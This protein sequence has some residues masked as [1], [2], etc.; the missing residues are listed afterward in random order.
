MSERIGG[1]FSLS[2]SQEGIWHA[3]RLGG[4]GA[5]Y[6]VGQAVE[7]TGALDVPAFEAALRRTVEETEILGL[8]FAEDAVG[9]VRVVPHP[10]RRWSLR[11]EEPDR[12]DGD[13]RAWMETRMRE[14]LAGVEDP[15]G[16]RLFS[17]LLFRLDSH[18]YC[19]FQG[20]NHLLLDGYACTLMADR[21]AEVYSALVGGADAICPEAEFVSL[22]E[23]LDEEERYR[24]SPEFTEDRRYLCDRFSDR[25]ELAEVPRLSGVSGFLKETGAGAGAGAV[26]RE[27]GSLASAATDALRSAADRVGLRTSRLLAAASGAFV[28]GMAGSAEALLSLPVTGRVSEADL[29]AR[30]TRANMLPLR[31]PVRA[32]ASLLDLARTADGALGELLR[33]Q[34]YRGEHLRRELGW[35]EGDRWHFGPYLNILPRTG[36]LAFGDCR[37]V[38]RDV[39]TRLV[40]DFGVLIDRA[41]S[42]IEITV[43]ANAALYDRAWVRAVQRSLVG[44]IAR[45]AE[46]PTAPVRRIG[47]VGDDERALVTSGWSGTARD[48]DA[49]MVV[50]RFR[51]WAVRTPGA[52]ALRFGQQALS[53]GELAARSDMLARGLVARGVGRESR[54]GLCLPR[55]AEMVVALLAVWKAGGAYVPLDPE[56]PAERLAFMVA[57]SG[58]ELVLAAEETVDRLLADVETVLVG[59]LGTD[60]GVLPDVPSDQLA[61]VIYTSGSTGRP[62]G[63]AVA[64]ASVAN[65]ASAMGPVLGVEPGVTALQFASFSFD[66]AVLDVAVTLA[67]GGTLAIA[68]AEERQDGAA[69]AAMVEAAGVEVASVVPSLLGVLEPNSVPGVGNWVLGA[70]RLEA[71]LA[72]KW[73]AGARVWNT[74]GPT[75]ATVI[76][77]ATLLEADITGEDVPPA[78][79]SPLPDIRTYVLD[80]FLRPVP[81]GVAGELYIAGS[82]LAR[83]YIGRA[84]LTAERFVACPF[85]DGGGRMYRTG[86]LA[87]W[88]A[89]GQLEFVGRADAQVKIRGFRVE[90][91]EVE[92]VLA[93]H[94]QVERAVVVVRDGRLVG[95]VVGDADGED[96]REFA[97]TRLPEYMVPSAVVVL[98]VFPLTVNGKVDRV[99]LPMPEAAPGGG[100]AAATPAEE[101]FCALFAEV[102]GLEEVGV[103]ESFFALGGDS[104]T[105]MLLVSRSRRAGL[106]VGA[107]QVHELRTPAQLA[108]VATPVDGAVDGA[109]P[110]ESAAGEVPLT[111]VM[112][113]V[114][115]RVGAEGVRAVV[116]SMVVEAPAGLDEAA[117]RDAMAALVERHAVLRA[118]LVVESGV[119]V[120]PETDAVDVPGAVAR[121]DV[122]GVDPAVVVGEQVEAAVG[123]LD[124]AAGVMVQVVW[125]DAGP[126]VPGRLVVVA[127]HLV[128]DAVSWQVLLP[129]LWSAYEALAEGRAVELD[130]VPV[131]F[132]AWA[133]ELAVE[134][135]RP[136]RVAELAAW[137]EVVDGPQVLLTDAPLDPLMDVGGTVREV[138]VTVPVEVTSAL[139]AAVP[140]AFHAGVDEV[141]LAGLVGAIG[142]WAADVGGFLVDVEGHGREPLSGISDLS[143]TVGWFT[144]SHPVR[145]AAG[146]GADGG[147][148]V[149]GVKEQVRAVPGDG[150]GY[151]LLRY[152]NPETADELAELPSAQVGFN[153]LGRVGAGHDFGAGSAPQAPVMHALELLGSVRES[154]EGPVL[155]LRLAFP[156]R[157]LGVGRARG[158]V[159]AWAGVLAD[160]VAD[161][162]AGA[163]GYSPSDFP[164]VALDQAGVEEIEAAVPGLAE[165]LPVAPLQEGLLFHSLFDEDGVDVYVE[166]MVLGLDGEVDGGRLRA[167]WQALVDR[168]AALRAGFVQAAGAVGPVQVVVERAELPWREVDLTELGDD[169]ADRVGAE[170]RS[171]RFDL[172]A[173]PLLR[174]ALVR[175]G[176]RRF[177]MVVTLHHLLLD[178]WSLPLVMRELWALYAAGGRASGLGVPVSSRPYWAWLAGRDMSAALEAW[179]AE[180]APVEEPTLVAPTELSATASVV[181]DRVTERASV[182]LVRDLE[183]VARGAGV[184]LNT[185]VQLAW[186]LVLGQLTGRREVVFGATVAGRPAELPGM[187][188]MLGLFINTLPVRVDLDGA[189]SVRETLEA[190]QA[191]QSALLD[192]QHVG[193]SEVQRAAGL[194]A[195]FDTLLAFENYPGNLD[196]QPLG[197]GLAVTATELRE[198]TNFALA[199]GVTPAPADGLAIRLDY[200]SGLFRRWSALRMARRLVRVLEQMAAD[201]QLRL[202]EIELLDGSE[203][204]AVVEEWNATDRMAEPGT[205][206]ERFRGWAVRTPAAAALW[207]GQQALSY[208][209]LAARSDMLARG[210][211]ARG[212]GRESRVGLCL[213]RG[214]EMVVALLA[215]WKAGGAYV[216]LDPEYPAERLAFMVADSGAELVL[217]AEETV[218]LLSVDVETVLLGELGSDSGDLPEV[219]GGQLA[220]VIYTSG[221]TGRPK[222]VAVTHA[223]VAN[224]ASAMRP[225]LGVEPGVAALQFASF[226]FDAAVL[227]VAV[228]LAAGGTLAIASA[229]ERQD[230]SALA[231]MVAAAGVEV[232]S[233][234]PSLLGV[235][236]SNSVPGVGNWVLGAERLEAGLAA[237][238]RA[239]AR[240]WNT[241]GP[242]E[243]TVITTAVLLEEGITGEDAPPAIGRPLPNVRT[244]V[245]D[246]F[247]RPVPDGV[248]G[249]L[250]VAG[251]GLARGYINRPD[252]TA[253]RF[254]ACPFGDGGRMYRTGDLARWAG[255]G[256]LEFVGRA[257]AQVKI[258]GFRVELGEVETVL[259]GHALVE[260]AVVVARDGRL[261]GY[262]LGDVEAEALRE[263]AATRLPEY[264][265]PSAVVVLDVFPLTVNG[266]VDRSALPAPDLAPADTRAPSTEVEE[267]FCALFAEV[268]GLGQVGLGDSF[269]ALGGDSIMSM[270]LASRARSAGWTMSPRQIFEEKTPERL[271]QVAGASSGTGDARR[272]D[273][274]VGEVP[275]T[276]VMRELLDRVGSERVGRIVQPGVLTLPPGLDRE[277]LV[278]A[279]H[280][281]MER[282]EVLRA[283]LV[284]ESG[285]LVV[286]ESPAV[287]VDG[288]VARVEAVG[289]DPAVLVGEQAEAAV[290]RLD[291]AAGVMVRVVWLDAGPEVPGRL[292]VVANHLVVDTVSWQVLLP[293]LQRALTMLGEGRA[294]ELEP[295]PV[296]FRAW[297]RELAVEAGRP[298]RVA[299]LPAWRAVV[300]GDGPD[301]LLTD[302]PLDPLVDVGATVRE[303]AVTVPAEVT[304]ALLTVV[305]SA[306]HAGVDEVLL[307]GLAGAVGEWA[308]GVGGFLVDVEGHGREP[309][310]GISDLSRTVGWFTSSRPVRLSAGVDGGVSVLGV[311]ERVRAVPGDG[312]GYGLLRWLNPETA[313]ELAGLPSAQVGFNYLGRV[314]TGEGF[315]A[316]GAPAASVMHAVELLCSVR[317]L[318]DGPV[319]ELRLAYPERLLGADRARALVEAWVDAL[320]GLA[321]DVRAG[322]GGHSPSDFPLVVLDQAGVEEVVAAVPGL[323]DVLPVAPLQEGLLFH[324]LFDEDGVDVYVEQMVLGLDGEVDGGRLRASWQALVDRHAALRAGFVQVAG[325]A[326]PVQVV[327]DR[328]ELPWREV[329]LTG[330]G[331]GAASRVG[332]EER[333]ARF[334]L[335]APPL[336]RVALVRVGH[337]QYQMVVTLHHLLLDGWS[338]PLVMRELWALYAADGRASGLGV[339]VSSRPYWTWLAGRDMSAAL[340]AWRAE[341]APIEEPTLVAPTVAGTDAVL[342]QS[343][344]VEAREGLVEGLERVARGAG[345][346][347]NTVVQL[348]WGLVLGQ[349]TGRRE[350]VFGATVAGRPAELPGMEAMLGLFINT[351]PVRVDLDGARS[352]RET[353][354]ALQARQSALL[355]H[356]HV[357]LSEVQRAAGPG[358][359]FDTLLAF[360]NYP[361]D[362]AAQPSAAGLTISG[363]SSRESTSFALALGVRPEDGLTLRL[364]YRPDAFD[365]DAARTLI[366][367]VVRALERIA[368]DPTVRLAELELLD[369][370]ERAVVVEEWNA[371]ARPTEPGTVLERFRRWAVET[372]QATAVRSGDPSQ[373]LSYA[374]LD[375]RSDA[376]ARGLV[377]RGVGRESRVGLCLPRGVEM[378][379]AVLAV[380]KAGGAYVPLDPEYPSERLAFM[381]GDSDAELVLVAEET[382]GRLP[383]EVGTVLPAELE[384]EFGEGPDS[385]AVDPGQL[386]Y[387]IYTSGSTGR[388]KGVAVAHASVAN[389]ASAMRPVLGVEPGVTA[390]QFASFGF[391]AAVLDVAVTLA[392][393]G[394]LA[395]ASSEERQDPS[396]LAAMVES[397][398]VDSASVVPSLLGALEPNSVPGVRNW[399]LG[400]ERLE[401]GLAARWREGARVWNTY[402]P[403]EATVI[404][405]AVLLEEGITGEDAPPVIGSPL[406][407]IRTYVLDAFLRPVPVGVA[408]ELYIAGSGLARGYVGRADLTAERFVACPF[409]DG[410]GRM[411]RTGD[412]VRWTAD[413]LLDFVGRADAQVKIRGFRVEL[414]EVETVLAAHAQV[415][416]AVVLARDGRLIGYTVGDADAEELRA[417]A[418]TRLPEY[419]VPSAVVVL[420]TFPLTVNGKIDRSALP[421]PDLASIA[422]RVPATPGEEAFCAL[423]A[424]VLGLEDVGVGDGFFELGG[425]SIMS[426]QLA[427]RARRSGWVVTPRQIFEE[428][429]PERLALV[430]AVSEDVS[431]LAGD[432]GVGEVPLTPVMRELLDRVGQAAVARIVQPGV[433]AAPAGLDLEVLVAALRAVM[434]RH[435]VLR[436][437]LVV[438]SGV[439]AVPEADAVDVSGLVARVDVAGVDPA[440]VVGEQVEAAVGRLDPAAGVMVQVVWLDAGPEVPGR[441]VVVA[442]HL[443]VDTVSWQVVLPDLELACTALAEGRPVELDPV[444]VSFRAW[445]RELA[446]EA[447]RPERVAELPAWRAVVAGDG[448]DAL[449]T[450]VPLDP[451][452]DVGGTVR[453]VAV[454]VPVEVTSALLTVVPSAFHAGVDEVLLAGL[455]GAVGEWSA[456]VGDGF[457]VDVEGHGREP[458]SGISDLSRTVGW[459]TSSRPVRLSAGVDGGVS[460]LGVKERVRA[461]PG[462]GLG[463]GLLRYVNSE[464]ADELAGLPSAQV[465]FN[466]LGRVGTGEG[467]GAGGAPEASVMHAV[468]LLG[469]VR[470]LTDGS[471][472]EL[473][474]A[475]PERLLEADRARALLEVWAEA[476]SGLVEQVRDGAG[477]HSPSDFPLVSLSQGGV[478]ELELAVPGLEDVWPLSPLQEGLLFHSSF[479]DEAGADVYAGQRALALDG[480]LDVARLRASW[481]VVLGRHAIL[482]AGFHRLVS[483]EAVQVVAREVE[484]PWREVDLSGLSE[485]AAEVEAARLSGEELSAGFDL[486]RG[487]LLRLLLLRLGERRHR[488]VMTTHH[489][490]LD[491]WSLPILLNE[492]QTVYRAG[493]GVQALPA[494]RSYRDYLSWLGRQD[495][496]AARAV[497]REELAG[498]EEP[499][500]VAPVDPARLPMR[501]EAVRVECSAELTRALNDVAR[502]GGVTMATV[503]QGAWALVLA[504]LSGRRDVV[505]GTTVA[506]RP[507]DLPGAESLIGLF[508]NTLP[509]RVELDGGESVLKMLDRLQRRRLGV[510]G[511][512][513]LGLA[514]IKQVAGPGA[515][516]DTLVVYENYPQSAEA[517]PDD[518]DALTIRPGGRTRDASHYPLGL[519]VAPGERMELQ[520]DHRP[521]LFDQA[522]AEE[523]LA[524]LVRVLEQFAEDPEMLLGRVGLL[525]AERLDRLTRD[526]QDISAEVPSGTLPDLLAEQVRRTP[527]APAL[528][529]GEHRLTYAELEAEAGRLA[530]YLIAVGVGPERRVAVVAERS[531]D[532]V[533]AL[534]A[535][536]MA[537]GAFVPLDP[538]HPTERLALVLEDSDP[539]AVLCTRASRAVLP[540]AGRGRATALDD[541]GV[542]ASV[543]GHAP[544]RVVDAERIVPLGVANAAYV[545]HTSGSTGRP[546][547]VV[548]SHAGLANLAW[549]QIDRFAVHAEARVLQFASLSFD[550]AVSELCM[551]LVSGAV[552]VVAGAEGL[553]PRVSLGEAVDRARATHVT[554]PPGVLAVEEVL[555]ES[556]ETLVVAGEAC[557]PG[558]VD[559]WSIG[560]R[561]VNAYG[562]TEVTVCAAMSL[563]LTLGA[564]SRTGAGDTDG[565]P[566]G[567][568]TANMRAYVLDEFLQPVPVGVAGELYVSGPG[569]ARGYSGRPDLTAERFVADPFDAGA[570]MYRTGDLVRWLPEGQLT[571]VGRADEQVKIRGFRIELGEVEAVLDDHPEVAQAVVTVRD[572]RLVAHVVGGA[573]A[574][575][576]REFVAVRLPEYMV[577]AAVVVLDAFPLTV[578][579]KVDRA[580][581]PAPEFGGSASGRQPGTAAE[582]AFRALFAEALGLA[583]GAIGV[584]DSFFELGGDSIMSMQLASR[585]RRSGWVVTPRQIFEEKTPERLAL[586]AVVSEDA[587][588]V[589]GDTGVGEVPWTPL[590]R[591]MGA[592]VLRPGFAQ[593][594][595]IGAPADLGVDAL[596]SGVEALL[597][598]HGMLRARAGDD[599]VLV[600]PEA[601][602]IDA[603]GLVARV[604]AVETAEEELDR[605]AAEAARLAVGRLDPAA[606][607]MVQVVWVD[608]GPDRVGRI[609]LAGHHLAVDGVSWRV[610]VPDLQAACEAAGAGRRPDLA[611]APTSFRAWAEGLRRAAQG[612]TRVGELDAWV[613]M[614]AGTAGDG[615][616]LVG[617]RALDPIVDTVATLRRRSWSV[618]VGEA[619]VLVGEVPGVFHCGLHEVLLATLAGAVAG[620]RT[621]SAGPGGFLV[622]VEGHGREPL[623]AGVDLSRTVG[624]FTAAYPVRLDASGVDLAEATAGG[625]AAGD[626]LKRVKEQVQAVPGDG[627]GHGVLRWLNPETASALEALPVPRIGFNYLGRFATTGAESDV[628]VPWQ[629]V[630]D[631]AV[632]GAAD[633]GMPV[634]HA[635]DAGAVVADTASGPELTLTLSWPGALLDESDVEELGRTWLGLLSGLA[636]HTA[637]PLAGGHTPSDF[638]LVSLS[639]EGVEELESAVSGLEDVWPLSPLQEGLLFHASLDEGDGADVY[640]GQRALALDGPLDVGRLRASWDVVLGRHAILR[641]GFHRLASGEAV[642]VVAGEVELPW[643]ETDL[644]G[645]SEAEAEVEAA[646]LSEDEL[647]VGFDLARGPLLRLLLLRLGERRHRLVMTSHHSVVDGWSLSV[648]IDELSAAYAAGGDAG[649]LPAVRSYRDYLAWLGRQDREA[650]RAAWRE[651]LAGAEEPTLVAP[652]DPA[653]L[654]LRPEAVRAE[655][656]AELTR[657]L[658][659]LTRERGFTMATV[660]QGAWALVLARLS[661]RR[662]VVFGTTVA[663]RPA[664][665]PGAESLIGLFINTLPVRVELAG[666]LSVADLLSEL[667]ARQVN[668]MGH[669][670]L[671]LAE[672]KQLAGPGAEFDT[673]VVYENY[674][675]SAAATPDG[676]DALTIRPGGIPH[677]AS[678]YPLGLIVA[679]GERMELQLDHRPDLIDRAQADEVLAALV[680]VLERFAEDPEMP[681]GRLGLL[682]G[683]R[684][685]RLT[686]GWQDVSPEVPTGTLPDLLAEQVRRTPDAPALESVEAAGSGEHVVSYAELEAEAGRLARYLIAV[687]V[688]PERRVA[689][690]AE[691]SVDTVVA[692]LA[693]SMAGG[694]FVPLDPGH[695]TERLALVLEDSD[696]VAVLCTRATWPVLPEGVGGRAIVLDDPETVAAVAGCAPGRV[697]DA[698]RIVPLEV[699]NAAYVIHTSGSTGRPKGVVVSHAGLAN[700]AWAQI[701]RFAVH[702]RARVLQFASLSFDAAVSELCMALVSGAVLVVAGAEGLPPQVS[703]GEAVSLAR[704]THVTVPPGVLAVEEVLP[705]ALETLVVAG[706]A[707]PPGLVDR[708]STGRRMVNAYGPT[709][710]TVCAAMSLPLT[711]GAGGSVPIGRPLRNARTFVLDEFLQPVPVGVAG[712]L[713]VSGPG[714]ARGYAGRP[715]LTAERFVAAPF[716]EGERM[717]RTGD[718]IRWT[719]EGQLE[720][721]GRAD[722]QVKIRGFRIELGEV[723][724][725]LE[726]HPQADHAVVMVRE[727]RLVGYV[728]GREVDAD[729]LRVFAS[730]RLPE[731]MVPAAM[732]VLDAFPFTVNGKVDRAAL[733]DPEFAGSGSTRRPGTAAEEA[734]CALFA[735]VLG[736]AAGAIGV[737]DSFFELGGDSI[738][739]M[740]LASRARRSG[741]V[742]TPRQIFE[743]KTPERLALVAVVSEDASTVAGDTGVGEVP[744]TPLMRSMG[745]DV[746]R[747]GFAQWT[748]I[749]APADLGVD[750]LTSGVEALLRTHGMLRARAGDDQ[751]LV[752]PEAGEIDVSGLVARVDAVGLAEGELDRLAVDAA[753]LAVG[754]LDPAAGVMVQVVWVDA[755]PDR[756]GR[757]ALAGHHLAVDGVSWRVLV[758]D[759]QAACEAAAA[760]GTPELEAAG[761]S[762]RAW[763]EG[764]RRVAQSPTRVGELDAWVDMVAGSAGDGEPLIGRRALDPAVDTTSTLRLLSWSLPAE[765]A[766]V[767]VGET[768]R[769][770]HCGLH[771]LLLAT[772]AGAVTRRRPGSE[773]EISTGIGSDG[774]LV[775]V[776]GHGREPLSAGMDL[777]RTVGWFTA[778]YPVRLDA[779]GV[780]LDETAAGGTAAGALVKR[781]KEQVQAVPGDGLGHGLLRHLNPETAATLEALPVPQIG[782]N[783]LGRF[784]TAGAVEPGQVE[785]W[786]TAGD[787]AVGGAADPGMPVLHALA[788]GAVVADTASG[789]ELTLTLSWPAALL[790]ETDVAELGRAWLALLS[791]LAAHTAGPQAGGHTPSDFSLLDL[792]QDEVDDLEAI[793]AELDEGR[794]L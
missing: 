599:Q 266:K 376:V 542:V 570:R 588:T 135:G 6:S 349:L 793:A 101:T 754:R 153:Y 565:V 477:G 574:S 3:Q 707:C 78:I 321:A 611:S 576:L 91:G 536:S 37:G 182:D 330:L 491:G 220:Y 158:L 154:A 127:N 419:M 747:P 113:E 457:L 577:P 699:A 194:G 763:A 240:V 650:A 217:V 710:V 500:L 249:D 291:P 368:A 343:L 454:T 213:P 382:A 781:V 161:V 643:R 324:S 768:P 69:L 367:R 468:E 606:G 177:Q 410:G 52:A 94:P 405:T 724:A 474:L 394:T 345:V 87:R 279:V 494:V 74:Y 452:V 285:V 407:N 447:G 348:A 333:S 518:P 353:L 737:G 421:A 637:D 638:P 715:D 313:G 397:N 569:L 587:S 790:D 785:P 778:A 739:S 439:L 492:L 36:E 640:A 718:L 43:E 466:Y 64:H 705:P 107:R 777:S 294:V 770:F 259:A 312:L 105:A 202:S 339:P 227:D 634:L 700:L 428:K 117:L 584:G 222:G 680:R 612:P 119:L 524:A 689:V 709:E 57:D 170:E 359:T 120:V 124:P 753:R 331:D 702:E 653:R 67:A 45:V 567:R 248:T 76:T 126:E 365:G 714:L 734:L 695:P 121:V 269:F 299:E 210:L 129:D 72:A 147:V 610:L 1:S 529:S 47:V 8:R 510:M 769:V 530:R 517:T 30:V 660:V 521:D 501:P 108:V 355:D 160:L 346:T 59:E 17:F 487:P 282:H 88:T 418:G 61:Y 479:D 478:R 5:L 317:E 664:D 75:E 779:S 267:V 18:R 201:P 305:P 627:L 112:R 399:V 571:F 369:E 24:N 497:W 246:A 238:W 642:Q 429:T 512:Q 694:A 358:A 595:V 22:S 296:S 541:P 130:P 180:L 247:L 716:G 772:L 575:E 320:T 192:H 356:Q 388:P 623:S 97:A 118:Q 329:D 773:A 629:T 132:R 761:T 142:E 237:K 65:L 620:R 593:W 103:G 98:D 328:V 193:L 255:D 295:V 29:W 196:A 550:A 616:P 186:G 123:R 85:G 191:R 758:P 334:D 400:A 218:E 730:S 792:D 537:G 380:W 198:S 264:M 347:L 300:A 250:Y 470:E 83:G 199:L 561:M 672:I 134:A 221:S 387:V 298:E 156:L 600:V 440:L 703:V 234:V 7:I 292:V 618:P 172:A 303:V 489:I 483:G 522:R 374:E 274:G 34:R 381:V 445:A 667:Q 116:Q 151:G 666:G 661:G 590:M 506:G 53:Y 277:V 271:A 641:A 555:P 311:K 273:A 751:V 706:E 711:P 509:V 704:A 750:A 284:P 756:V 534:L 316:G 688:G 159:D 79:G 207:F 563:P 424:E 589:A 782:F 62:K 465:G 738:M 270:Q 455:A 401:A 731:Y 385:A 635:L 552:L 332:A 25:P 759:L 293:D 556:L 102:L 145:L 538:G 543:A 168:H 622:E 219:G 484:L 60:S 80:A 601:G 327:V 712:E 656:G 278:A 463:Y 516:F 211:V 66:A 125:L 115:D 515:E 272:S 721:V 625:A 442:N 722:E 596:T 566:I 209:E 84:D 254:V 244:Y 197:D 776:E 528:E 693:V 335:A 585:A 2:D 663:G 436:A 503:V 31:F 395:I 58:A 38:A 434:N 670:Y 675:H 733:P 592:D 304:S 23:A 674:P 338:L 236:E 692:L 389:L 138:A 475:W 607:V 658:E 462:D 644:S 416:R 746:L 417:F 41:G 682:D 55:G 624:W 783:Y 415:E 789:P 523:V 205:V 16:E 228:T 257:D 755:G 784:A 469:S 461:V 122:V 373:S 471:V 633:P 188:A 531:V 685:D 614:V 229:G 430:A 100:R 283:R 265:V 137:R 713:Y 568:P 727:G 762:F 386:A 673:L 174:V 511:H 499:T 150:L 215:V 728:V 40:E 564:G 9:G 12:A 375:A 414:G 427:S 554:V 743:E 11:I 649:A 735:E 598:T 422:T 684:L 423:F 646:R 551:A 652:V 659:D 128:V 314:G 459:F 235:L 256:Q 352:V 131:S 603:S 580:A 668:L 361:G 559:R 655:C 245:L 413:G 787:T 351:L 340:E 286:P 390:L 157:L 657:A 626:L 504:R 562:P 141:L 10:A 446:V 526:W 771:E 95:Y 89:D 319:L 200:R 148:S 379:T 560:R 26:L 318:A 90:L 46:D 163:G 51:G 647:S 485:A 729:A 136:E 167:S 696:P 617:H 190:L 301:G 544:G 162:R 48:V 357:G 165:V 176:D 412:L 450:D 557:P 431:A 473:V 514:E 54:V 691:R 206:V 372:P 86:D 93:A 630:G 717:Y 262:V 342:A 539:V 662:D 527:D 104:I 632:G 322:A 82:G 403:T 110:A 683:V 39:S 453:E 586:V 597:R 578:N 15:R 287:S 203:R 139:L 615:D 280:A 96:A 281:V 448:P 195:T 155:E 392:A 545:I 341:L 366:D 396:A 676:P 212:V 426:M 251:A 764:L 791:G 742:V 370:S 371:T 307:A 678:H 241:Y 540:A 532:T 701:D 32:G 149:L 276:P 354:R 360:E 788:A 143:R 488:L 309:L 505:F 433:M 720:F 744:W 175:V 28:S 226:S 519:I 740:Q 507:A 604:D 608:A 435:E 33:H 719:A 164:L 496:E 794:F 336:L 732:V 166:Q 42:G 775:E 677:D 187:E 81:V 645:L 651:E 420:D 513:H 741:W 669:Q 723:E 408:G 482:R 109:R 591:S 384:I 4:T 179:R 344:E 438:E 476:L 20:Y 686:R 774:F 393:G 736:L 546:K 548:V 214:A 232:A 480:V 486:G 260:R 760:G 378:V 13:P 302:V 460:V 383:A 224:L 535:V 602:E 698:E 21:V 572:G 472:L 50:E 106:V 71:G 144:A 239:G 171:A 185:V 27:T 520:L 411:Y 364:D 690:V 184:T 681:L 14:E 752:V 242:T 726:A 508:I 404:T 261:V 765:K 456:G 628:V 631:T 323:V 377:A 308:A 745:A 654:P 547:G 609:V 290:G 258:R 230:A 208:G 553:P 648:L 549:A 458:L 573:E 315:G 581:L 49:S 288:L 362:P 605:I 183:R 56:Y 402:G 579:G 493:A 350:V 621:R 216:P 391:D 275:L 639:Q 495:R 289:V 558:L 409:G 70:E 490:V 481:D 441:L 189:R 114:L 687:G 99:A 253:E 173:P 498:A 636:A 146:A 325:A 708:W 749:G 697:V 268:L 464:T 310:S 204:A 77:T 263:F 92:A 725:A 68:S 44:F 181:L 243:A 443:V 19:W 671:G 767:L 449:L 297:A 583:A 432:T 73:R 223:S 502:Q 582:H 231:A 252:L 748:V 225:V 613:D 178:G 679:P 152:V 757:I 766:A 35:P 63:V 111:P 398:G 140:A 451:L 337:R 169:V 533:V 425:D 233:V 786:Q 665:L 437:R 406:P 326:G 780:D 306:F 594:T 619:A 363:V 467:F 133:R 525:D 444:P